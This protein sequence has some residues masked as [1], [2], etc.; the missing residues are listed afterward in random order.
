MQLSGNTILITG[1]AS[2][3]GLALAERFLQAGSEVIICGRRENKLREAK[4][5][6]P[7]LHTHLCDVATAEQR[8]ALRDWVFT[9]FP[10]LNVLINNAGIQRRIALT[11]PEHWETTR[12][13]LAINLEAPIHLTTLLLPH[14][15]QRENAALLNVT[16]GLA[17]SPLA[18]VPVYCATKA[19][20]HS[21]TLSLRHQLRDSGVQVI[22][23][24]P[25]AVDTDL[26]GPGLHTFGAPVATFTDAIMAQLAEGSVEATFGMSAK[27]NHASQAELKA[28]FRAMNPT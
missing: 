7:K 1:G 9:N 11:Q 24:I 13:E 20:L 4:Q 25:P 17:F 27:A 5:K 22:E 3:I 8:V 26:G 19:A 18:G 10:A 15:L 2:G 16:S 6:L 14:L 12:E 28:I 21:F 23:I